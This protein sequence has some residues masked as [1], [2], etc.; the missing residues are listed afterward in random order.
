M[1][2][3]PLL[4]PARQ[5]GSCFPAPADGALFCPGQTLMT[6]G[7]SHPPW[8]AIP[9]IQPRC[10]HGPL[11]HPPRAP[12]RASQISDHPP[13]SIHCNVP[14]MH[15]LHGKNLGTSPLSHRF[16]CLDS[17][18]MAE[19]RAG[20]HSTRSHSHR[21]QPLPRCIWQ[22]GNQLSLLAPTSARHSATSTR[23]T[24]PLASNVCPHTP[25]TWLPAS[26]L[27]SVTSAAFSTSSPDWDVSSGLSPHFS[28]LPNIRHPPPAVIGFCRPSPGGW[29]RRR[30]SNGRQRGIPE[31]L[32]IDSTGE[33]AL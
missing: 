3:V 22:T 31:Q 6:A 13:A 12:A 21:R 27:W 1:V 7:R 23:T 33:L 15:H 26:E 11:P 30:R 10:G 2:N 14:G 32:V 25:E 18:I 9:A 8:A 24:H 4:L 16:P 19:R 20:T 28:S 17:I 29:D 5:A